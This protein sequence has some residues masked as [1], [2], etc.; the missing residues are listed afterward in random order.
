MLR[1]NMFHIPR[2]GK[3]QRRAGM[4]NSQGQHGFEPSNICHIHAHRFPK[5]N[6]RWGSLTMTHRQCSVSI[7]F[8]ITTRAKFVLNNN[9]TFRR[10]RGAN[11]LHCMP[12]LP[13]RP[14]TWL[15]SWCPPSPSGC[16]GGA[17]PSV[18]TGRSQGMF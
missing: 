8:K 17:S 7:P 18:G 4:I 16:S 10:L 1:G 13:L 14:R 9:S 3:R 6:T 5:I 15:T 12:A 2:E 11:V